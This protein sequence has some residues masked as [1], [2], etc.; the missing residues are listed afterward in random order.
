[1]EELIIDNFAGGGGASTGIEM[2]LHRLVDVAINHDPMAL[3]M[4]KANHPQTIHLCEDVFSVDPVKVAAGRPVGL[5]WLSPDCKHFSKAKGGKPVSKKIRGLAWVAVKWAA[6]VQPRIIILEN[7]EEFQTWGPLGPDNRPCPK[8]KGRTFRAFIHRLKRNGYTVE[9]RELRA[10][11]YGAPTIRKRLFLIARRDG[12]P[13][14]WPEPTHGPGRPLPY[15]TAAEC[16]DWTI[17]CP[18]IFERKR[19]LCDAT[20]R[21]IAMGLKKYVFEAAK[22]FIVPLTH[23]GAPRVHDIQEPF[24]TITGA[25][26]GELALCSPTLIVA[27]VV[28]HALITAFLGK[29]YGGNTTPGASLTAPISTVTAKD[30]HALVAAHLVRQFGTSKGAAVTAPVGTIM[31]DGG[32]KTQLVK[33]FFVKYYG[34]GTVAGLLR[35]MPTLT[36]RDRIGLVSVGGHEYAITDIGMRMLQPRELYR[37][38]GFPESYVIDPEYNG[39]PMTKTAQVRHVG[40]SVSPPIARA[41]VLA[42]CPDMVMRRGEQVRMFKEAAA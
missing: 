3:A 36:S 35:P 18:S 15:R 4:H 42:N 1:M 5:V 23:Q 10:C 19:P 27:G 37:A 31:P 29:H 6:T 39:K 30:H 11:D 16:I 40:N 33:A 21:R 22:P 12:Q 2:A 17:P 38:Q 8:R 7:V 41:I 28:K 26:R 25:H 9:W 34:T 24:R 13:I 14:V 32:G 20:M